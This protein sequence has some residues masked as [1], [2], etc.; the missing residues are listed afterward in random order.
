MIRKNHKKRR[1][2]FRPIALLLLASVLITGCGGSDEP[3]A[4]QT[5]EPEQAE[6]ERALEVED[7]TMSPDSTVIAVGQT[8]VTYREYLTYYNFKLLYKILPN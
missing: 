4:T 1:M 7:G 2:L 5:P 8:P 6:H 3:E